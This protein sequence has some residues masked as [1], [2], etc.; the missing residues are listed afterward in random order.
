MKYFSGF[1]FKDEIEIFS[2]L[3]KSEFLVA[4]FSYGAIRAFEYVYKENSR[5]DKLILISPA[6][7]QDRDEKFKKLQLIFFK[8]DPKKYFENFYENVIFPSNI[9]I[10]K[11]KKDDSF[12]NLKELLYY[13]WNQDKLNELIK[14]GIKIEVY[15]GE[16]DKIINSN[17][18]Y[19]F[20]KSF[21]T[22]Y[23]IKNVGHLLV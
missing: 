17:L 18:A 15:L 7:F 8:K 10:E 4:G 23:F 20:F 6:F 3:K 9:Y 22:V 14:R 5:V 11:Y 13:K 1:G 21:A 19:D 12:E 2:F 16:K